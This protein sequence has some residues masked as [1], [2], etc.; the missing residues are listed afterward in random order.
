MRNQNC[1]NGLRRIALLAVA[2]LLIAFATGCGDDECPDGQ[3]LAQ[4]P[5]EEEA[6][7]YTLCE[8][9][10]AC[11]DGEMC[12]EDGFCVPGDTPNNT[13]PNNT[14][15]NNTEPNNTEPNNTTPNNTEPNN[16]EP[17]NTTPNN[18]EPNNTEPN[19]TTPN[20]TEP[21]NTTPNNSTEDLSEEDK[22]L[23]DNFCHLLLGCIE[24]QCGAFG[25]GDL[26][27]DVQ[28]CL[29]GDGVSDHGCY[30]DLSGP[31]ADQERPGLE[32]IVY[33]DFDDLES[34]DLRDEPNTCDDMVWARCGAQGLAGSQFQCGC[35]AP[36]NLGAACTEDDDC[37]AGSLLYGACAADEGDDEVGD[38]PDDGGFCIAGQCAV[39]G[40]ESP[41]EVLVD[42][43]TG[44]GAEGAGCLVGESEMGQ[45]I[46][47]VC[48]GL[49]DANDDCG[50]G[51]ACQIF[52]PTREFNAPG[53]GGGEASTSPT[54]EIGRYCAPECDEDDDCGD[55]D[56]FRCGDSGACEF[57]CDDADAED[58]CDAIVGA[59]CEDDDGTEWCVL[60]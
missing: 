8:D 5:G 59:S 2:A 11:D 30:G 46:G 1:T 22:E 33:G 10:D 47:E 40:D 38:E 4:Q 56:E 50:D 44:C 34:E 13:E 16:T 14:E 29:E 26:A 39:F 41:G 51:L 19:N 7:C 12:H 3:S 15:P 53:M 20:N 42:E 52:A 36:G 6:Q 58:A 25:P 37:D 43:M 28:N 35:D 60:D 31:N 23:C 45:P 27:A 32:G 24:E 49:C 9:N 18:T 55:G 17:N 48:V 21:N 57:E 54:G